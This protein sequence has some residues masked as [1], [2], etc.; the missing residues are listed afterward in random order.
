MRFI[1]VDWLAAHLLILLSNI[2]LNEYT[3]ICLLI[4]VLMD[5]WVIFSLGLL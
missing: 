3:T 5:M 2:V 1:F 4:H